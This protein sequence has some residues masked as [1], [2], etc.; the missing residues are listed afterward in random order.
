VPKTV[1]QSRGALLP[2]S[3][4]RGYRREIGVLDIPAFR[5]T[6]D[7]RE[8]RRLRDRTLRELHPEHTLPALTREVV[9]D[10]VF[11]AIVAPLHDD[12]ALLEL[13]TLE[14]VLRR[15]LRRTP[16]DGHLL[17]VLA[18]C[19]AEKPLDGLARA[20]RAGEVGVVRRHRRRARGGGRG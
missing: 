11:V 6:L 14:L 10:A 19:A 13:G 9:D 5:R 7:R 3:A 2:R 17:Q 8:A 1:P 20:R 4:E 12:E 15:T 18:L 16:S